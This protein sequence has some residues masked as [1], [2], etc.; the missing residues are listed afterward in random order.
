MNEVQL[1]ENFSVE[2]RGKM[3]HCKFSQPFQTIVL[4]QF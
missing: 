1:E 4:K 2:E 3:L